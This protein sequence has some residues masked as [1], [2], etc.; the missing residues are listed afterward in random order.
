[1]CSVMDFTLGRIESNSGRMH[2]RERRPSI[3][4]GPVQSSLGSLSNQ[5]S[6]TGDGAARGGRLTCNE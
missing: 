6:T 2:Y 5:N 4:L 3:K 1:V